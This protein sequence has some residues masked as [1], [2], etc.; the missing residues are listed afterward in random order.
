MRIL[1][2]HSNDIKNYPPV[3]SLLENL[4]HNGHKVTIICKD[5]TGFIKTNY[6]KVVRHRPLNNYTETNKYKDISLFFKNRTLIK[7]L[8]EQ[9]AP[10]N[11][12][13]WTTTAETVREV[14]DLLL[15]HKHVMQLMELIEY[16][17]QLPKAQFLKYDIK[18]Y[19]RKAWKVV[20]PEENRAYIQ[21]VWWD[22]EDVPSVLP[23]KPY[24][25]TIGSTPDELVPVLE[26][27]EKEKRKIVLYQGVFLPDRN[28]DA[29]AEAI[30]Q[31]QDRYCMY[32]MGGSTDY[33]KE[34]C[35]RH[36]N[37][38]YVPYVAAPNHLLVTQKADIGLLPYIPIKVDNSSILNALYCAPNKIYEY[39]AY[40]LPMIGSNV[41]GL[42]IPFE[43]FGMGLCCE[44]LAVP[45]VKKALEYIDENY[46]SMKAAC[47]T[48]YASTDLDG[49]VKDILEV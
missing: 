41:L 13:V 22:L 26:E 28:L 19:A 7:K 40:G 16:V 29:F 33:Q 38:R 31:M 20:V 44:K 23:N 21:K 8:F 39:A 34:L 32:I 12:V 47:S 2:V 6:G 48:F 43:K 4:V 35:K 15:D 45:D 1:V 37:I 9:E 24:S 11:E 10:K 17:P 49:I 18:K 36:P 3:I 42:K 25:M 5:K 27:M 14:G 46:E 30:D